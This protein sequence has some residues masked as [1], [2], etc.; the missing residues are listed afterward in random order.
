MAINYAGLPPAT[1]AWQEEDHPGWRKFADIGTVNLEFG[2][3]LPRVRVAYETFGTRKP[4][5]SN[6]VLVLH[7]LSGDAHVA[8]KDGPGQITGGWWNAVVGPGKALD[9]DKWWVICPN[10]LGGC[11]GTTGPASIAPDGAP[12]GSR[13]PRITVRD[14]IAVEA[15]LADRLEI[16]R[17]AMVIGG[18]MGG[19]RALEWTVSFPERVG[20]ALFLA[21]GAAATAD[22]IGLYSSQILAITSDPNW[23]GGDYYQRASG[24]GPHIGLGL[25]R[26]IAHLSYR[27]QA[28][29]HVRFGRDAQT[30]E[31]PLTDGRFA[32]ESYLD[33]HANKLARRFDAGSYVSL[34][35]AMLS[36]DIGRGR[37]GVA[38]ALSAMTVPLVV[39]GIDHDRLY[40]L[41]LQ[42][43]VANLVPTCEGLDVIRSPFGHDGFL[44][45]G[46]DVGRLIH[47]TIQL[48]AHRL[49]Q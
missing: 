41:H 39:A 33:H 37:G 18:S 1:G 42:E 19:M 29:L 45:E 16:P 11:Q 5:G 32:V 43:E 2:D 7:A 36:H 8:G 49:S 40:P 9:T 12:W 48:S 38:A 13:F 30:G 6:A 24:E 46:A 34:T 21:A 4:D 23:Q 17:W 14:Q 47:K 44:I 3:E 25:A 28:E 22:E 35:R 10:V 20:A 15:S 31:N 26:R 27:T